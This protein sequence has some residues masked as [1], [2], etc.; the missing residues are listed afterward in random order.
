MIKLFIALYVLKNLEIVY[1]ALYMV[2][3]DAQL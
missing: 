3:R 1:N 2:V